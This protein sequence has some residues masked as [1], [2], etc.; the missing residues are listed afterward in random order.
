LT[1]FN[2]Y[3][4]I[5]ELFVK[6]LEKGVVP[7]RKTW[8]TGMP[9]S[10]RQEYR[11][12][13]RFM[14]LLVAD[15]REYTSNLWLTWNDV[16]RLGGKVKK[17]SR[18]ALVTYF[19][20][21]HFEGKEEGDDP[22]RVP[23]LR[24]YT[25]FN[26]DVVEGLPITAVPP[27]PEG[28]HQA[29]GDVLKGYKDAPRLLHRMSASPRYRPGNDTMELPPAGQ[30]D[31]VP[32]YWQTLSHEL[33]HST[34]H[35]SRLNRWA[36]GYNHA[37]GSEDYSKEELIAELGS[38]FLMHTVGLESDQTHENSAAYLQSWLRVLKGDNK[39]VYQAASKAQRA[40]DYIVG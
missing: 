34:G 12:V 32:A 10:L 29:A 20:V 27:A 21:L 26:A 3:D 39:F 2:I 16:Q 18:S 22:T 14:L 11:G 17:G 31:D 38:A 7:W 30:F 9:R 13:N 1:K 19:K 8:R 33:V 37:F 36:D 35:R 6:S 28:D 40:A 4:H 25:V 15:D 23:M 24:Y 5:T